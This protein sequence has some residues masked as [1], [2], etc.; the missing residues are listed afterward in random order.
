MN[1]CACNNFY[2]GLERIF[3]DNN[4]QLHFVFSFSL[5]KLST[6]II[7]ESLYASYEHCR[8]SLFK[9]LFPRLT[10]LR[11]YPLR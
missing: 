10:V 9:M 11:L 2:V 3:L 7:I 8:E 1:I 6:V 4:I 5:Q